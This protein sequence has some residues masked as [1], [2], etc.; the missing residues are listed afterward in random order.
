MKKR[1]HRE[2]FGVVCRIPPHVPG[3]LAQCAFCEWGR[4]FPD[5]KRMRYSAVARASASLR[6]HAKR[7]HAA[8]FPQFS[9]AQQILGDVL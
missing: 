9:T 8:K 6:A 5:R 4:F 7:A 2:F 1:V 3:A